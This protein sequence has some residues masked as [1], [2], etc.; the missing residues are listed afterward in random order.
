MPRYQVQPAEAIDQAAPGQNNW[1]LVG[2]VVGPGLLKDMASYV[3]V[4][5]EDL[6]IRVTVDGIVITVGVA[7]THALGI[8]QYPFIAISSVTWNIQFSAVPES[9]D[10]PFALGLTMEIRKVTANG[11]G[12][13]RGVFTW[14]AQV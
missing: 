14:C 8:T 13:L 6:E 4:A 10:L 11:A 12:N 3:A 1:Y 2:T 9:S 5:G 7:R